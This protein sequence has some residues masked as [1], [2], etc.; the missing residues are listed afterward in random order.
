MS[1]YVLNRYEIATREFLHLPIAGWELAGRHS[2]G[3]VWNCWV[4]HEFPMT[5]GEIGACLTP[6]SNVS[7]QRRTRRTS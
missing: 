1:A 2:P 6:T 7:K 4:S 3:R 5:A